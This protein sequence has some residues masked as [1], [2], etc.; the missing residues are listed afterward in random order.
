[1]ADKI[2]Q[3]VDQCLGELFS[4]DISLIKHDVSERAIAHKLAEYLQTHFPNL[5]VDC[6]YNRNTEKG[7]YYPK[8]ILALKERRDKEPLDVRDEEILQEIST[9]P[10]IIIHRRNTNAENL[11]VIEIKKE[12]SKVPHDF[13]F[14]KLMAF[15][16]NSDSSYSYHYKYGLFILL[17]TGTE[18]PK[19]T[20]LIWFTEGKEIK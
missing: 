13:D 17:E 12:N 14:Q 19:K 8:K 10:D 3:L 6:E 16:E 15:T 11:L 9:Y 18:K 4:K 1:M 2:E 20:E 5:N 7:Q